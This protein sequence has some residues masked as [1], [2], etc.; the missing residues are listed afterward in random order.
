MCTFTGI[1]VLANRIIILVCF[2]LINRG[3]L[4]AVN[5]INIISCTFGLFCLCMWLCQDRLLFLCECTCFERT[6]FK[7]MKSI[8]MR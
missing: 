5:V 7:E 3:F 6:F 1:R 8:V 4:V 2:L